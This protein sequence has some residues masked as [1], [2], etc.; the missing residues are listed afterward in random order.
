MEE[1]ESKNGDE[2]RFFDC[3][4]DYNNQGYVI[5]G[6]PMSEVASLV[7]RVVISRL[8]SRVWN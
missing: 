3:D 1:W 2:G 5:K 7:S 8:L 6:F 4:W